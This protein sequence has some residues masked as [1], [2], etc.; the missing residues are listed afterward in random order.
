MINAVKHRTM[1]APPA[2]SRRSVSQ[3]PLP[4][5]ALLLAVPGGTRG[6]Q[7]FPRRRHQRAG[8]GLAFALFIFGVVKGRFTG[9][10]PLKGGFQTMIIGGLAA[11][12]AFGIAKLVG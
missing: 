4:V 8:L 9:I 12:A 7:R 6:A 3:P 2:G 5:K 11:A 1:L 10:N